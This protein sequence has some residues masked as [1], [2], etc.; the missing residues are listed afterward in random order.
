MEGGHC[1]DLDQQA[2]SDLEAEA[3]RHR[4]ALEGLTPRDVDKLVSE[5][6]RHLDRVHQIM[7]TFA[8][9]AAA[10]LAVVAVCVTMATP[11]RGTYGRR[12]CLRP[13]AF[14]RQ[15]TA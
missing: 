2:K 8:R 7:G 3:R 1:D 14:A 13:I 10:G 9:R 11:A 5:A 4:E 12:T 15:A 6:N